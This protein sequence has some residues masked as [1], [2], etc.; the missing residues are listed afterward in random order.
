MH[1][2]QKRMGPSQGDYNL[3]LGSVL[4][5]YGHDPRSLKRC[6]FWEIKVSFLE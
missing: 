4:F 6:C 2:N 1:L 3:T 5:R